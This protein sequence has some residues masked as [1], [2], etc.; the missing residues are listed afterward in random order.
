MSRFIRRLAL[1][2]D[3]HSVQIVDDSLP[4]GE[5]VEIMVVVPDKDTSE[6]HRENAERFL[7]LLADLRAEFAASHPEGITEEEIMAEVKA[8]RRGE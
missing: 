2:T 8:H 6:A 7:A 3:D 5:M 1:V 4:T